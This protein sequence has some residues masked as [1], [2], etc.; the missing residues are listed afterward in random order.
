[1]F[2][3][4]HTHSEHSIDSSCPITDMATAQ[5][6]AGTTIFAVT[7]HFDLPYYK[8]RNSIKSI[9]ACYKN[10]DELNIDGV[11]I[12][13]GIEIS[14]MNWDKKDTERILE[15]LKPDV[16]IG[17]VHSVLYKGEISIHLRDFSKLTKEE[18]DD[19]MH[20]YF[21]C[22][23]NNIRCGCDILGHL[24]LPL[25]Y[26][27]AK[28]NIFIDLV[29]YEDEINKILDY[30]IKNNIALEINTSALKNGIKDFLP[31]K[32]IIEKY[33]NMGG[34]LITLGSDAHTKENASYGFIEA[35][36]M[37]LSL[38]IT[39]AYYFKNRQPIKYSL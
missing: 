23:Y 19:F 38:G 1:M 27:G 9:N 21:K 18:L 34:K 8:A 22:V 10:I 30:I 35:K 33:K 25:R 16:V 37:L 28:Y 17:S 6:N 32:N 14:E 2:V 5:K 20:L 13:K 3:D 15:E 12:L 36:E 4:M 29:P 31:D 24:T 39:E 7:D 11:E 26:L